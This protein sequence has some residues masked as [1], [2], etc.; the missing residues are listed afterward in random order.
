MV[1]GKWLIKT[2]LSGKQLISINF[3]A[4]LTFTIYHLPF[5]IKE[6]FT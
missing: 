6:T 4:R 3:Y 5:T 2:K 1:N